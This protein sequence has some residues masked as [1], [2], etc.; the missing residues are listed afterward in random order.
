MAGAG[1]VPSLLAAIARAENLRRAKDLPAEAQ[2]SHDP[3]VRRAAARAL[4][5][6]LDAD[7]GPLL[8]AL[9]DEDPEVVAWAGYGLGESCKGREERHVRAI[10]ARLSSCDGDR[11]AIP[12]MLRALGRCGDDLAE[13]T[14]RVWLLRGAEGAESAAYALGEIAARRP[15]LSVESSVALLDAAEGSPPLDAALY[16]FGRAEDAVFPRILSSQTDA[17]AGTN[18]RRRVGQAARAALGRPGP[19]RIF[20]VRALSCAGDAAAASELARVL[21]SDDYTTPERADA[22]HGL[23]R[24][25][26]AGQSALADALGLLVPAHAETLASDRLGVLLAALGALSDDPPKNAEAALWALARLEPAPGAPPAIVRRASAL[27]CRAAEKLARGGWDSDILGGCDLAD[28]SAGELAQLAAIDRGAMAKPK[29]AAWT[30][31]ARSLHPRVR[32]AALEAIGRHPELGDAGRAAIADGLAANEP[33]VVAAA[34]EVLQAHPERAVVLADSERRAALDPQ[35]PA[36]TAAPARE[37]DKDVARALSAALA[38]AWNEDLIETRVSLLDAALT[39]GLDGARAFALAACQDPN[40]TIRARAAKA[41]ASA[42]EKGAACPAPDRPGAVA[43][44]VGHELA[45]PLRVMFETDS[46]PLAVRFDP[47]LAPVSVTRFIA[48]ARSGFYT[49]VAVHRVVPGF[50]VQLGDRGGDGYGGSGSLLRDETSPVP[51]GPFDVGVALAGRDTASSQIFI[52]L[53]RY[54]HLDGQYTHVGHAEGDWN[55]VAEGD[56]ITSVRVDE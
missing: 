28:G 30:R 56:L 46:G 11:R 20:A 7:D 10:A 21:S 49:G 35:A 47:A 19:E 18:L 51:F 12:P 34:A 6:I 36:P 27:R 1:E 44:E 32:E 55:A 42:G 24:L 39:T 29:R 41:L 40:T 22:A 53:A 48:L 2:R 16:A 45:R 33:G 38:R 14:L 9:E 50:V 25:R 15:P 54:P 3:S 37:L 5:R 8:R 13:R 31:L 43:P 23:T 52:T 4:A 26:K 17:S